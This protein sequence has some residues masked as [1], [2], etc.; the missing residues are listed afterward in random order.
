MRASMHARVC[1][2]ACVYMCVCGRLPRSALEE[3]LVRKHSFSCQ[4][5][6]LGRCCRISI[7]PCSS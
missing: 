3:C 7:D 4:V 6:N 5:S 2:R 1:A